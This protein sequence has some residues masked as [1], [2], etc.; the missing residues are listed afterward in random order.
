LTFTGFGAGV[1]VG[2]GVGLDTVQAAPVQPDEHLHACLLAPGVLLVLSTQSP[3]P[4]H[5]WSPP[6]VGQV[7]AGVGV[8]FNVDELHA[9]P[10]KTV[11]STV[12]HLH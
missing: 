8:G 10:K 11:L 7:G 2:V 3:W 1:G 9:R 5:N 12:S 6:P 4:L